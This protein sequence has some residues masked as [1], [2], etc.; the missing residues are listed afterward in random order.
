M[1]EENTDDITENT[2][3]KDN[4]LDGNTEDNT[5]DNTVRGQY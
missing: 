5:E 4:T 2:A 3:I 1:L